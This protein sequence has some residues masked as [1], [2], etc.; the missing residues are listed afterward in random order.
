MNSLRERKLWVLGSAGTTQ[1]RKGRTRAVLQTLI[2]IRIR[3]E[4]PAARTTLGWSTKLRGFALLFVAF[5]LLVP[6]AFAQTGAFSRIG[7]GARGIA[8][9]SAGTADGSGFGMPHYNPA[10]TPFIGRQHVEASTALMTHDR[11]IQYLQVG[12]SLPP[13]AGVAAGLTRGAVTDI[14]GRD[15]SGFPTTTYQTEEY[16]FFLAFGIKLSDR[17]SGGLAMQVFRSELFDDLDPGLSIGIDLGLLYQVTPRLA[18]GLVADDLLGK[19]TYEGGSAGGLVGGTTTSDAFPTRLRL[20]TSYTLGDSTRGTTQILADVEAQVSDR[21]FVRYRTI[22]LGGE[23]QRQ[24]IVTEQTSADVFARIGMEHTFA[25][26]PLSIQ[27]GVGGLSGD[28]FGLDTLR[29][30]AGFAVEQTAGTIVLRLQY[31][32]RL[33]PYGQGL[34]HLITVRALL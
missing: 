10:L 34:M 3:R 4:D 5:L 21:E 8:M 24:S 13:R 22:I 9:G 11:E 27:A 6:T 25:Q 30:S 12:A 14:D 17:L 18:L 32:A 7:F 31:A 26:F 33:E 19:Y 28:D 23:P 29:P 2:K 15:E 1:I 16:H 20:G